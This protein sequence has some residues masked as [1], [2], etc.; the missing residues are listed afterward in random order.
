M[1]ETPKLSEAIPEAT[2]EDIETM[3]SVQ[4]VCKMKIASVEF[5]TKTLDDVPQIRRF[6]LVDHDFCRSSSN[7]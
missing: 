4:K 1:K 2:L 7:G 6:H 5:E 3:V